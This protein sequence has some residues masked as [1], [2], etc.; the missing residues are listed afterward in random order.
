MIFS[1]QLEDDEFSG[2]QKANKR[3]S[4][5]HVLST[6]LSS[7]SSM[8]SLHESTATTSGSSGTDNPGD[9]TSERLFDLLNSSCITNGFN[10][11]GGFRLRRKVKPSLSNEA[12][13]HER[14]RSNPEKD[15]S[16]GSQE[17]AFN[18]RGSP[19]Q[20]FDRNHVHRRSMFESR[21]INE[22]R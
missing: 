6:S 5:S 20:P 2:K 21:N 22:K 17:F 3:N 10:L 11:E 15:F 14:E 16:E 8:T 9:E 12:S 18:D 7:M 4:L 19:L 13:M 1:K